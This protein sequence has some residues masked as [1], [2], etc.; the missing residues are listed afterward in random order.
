MNMEKIYSE[1]QT[2]KLFRT[3]P[4]SIKFLLDYSKSL[5]VIDYQGISFDTIL[6]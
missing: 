6:N 1:E 3:R 2:A 5:R 4:E